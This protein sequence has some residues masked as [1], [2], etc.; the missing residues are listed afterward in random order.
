MSTLGTGCTDIVREPMSQWRLRDSDKP[1][2]VVKEGTY[3]LPVLHRQDSCR[4]RPDRVPHPV[5]PSEEALGFDLIEALWLAELTHR[6][7][8]VLPALDFCMLCMSERE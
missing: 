4:S 7:A 3:G 5:L 6:D 8:G 1:V 2:L